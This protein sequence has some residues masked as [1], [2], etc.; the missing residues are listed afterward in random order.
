MS[1]LATLRAG[2][3]PPKVALLPDGLFFTRAL[4]VA[5]GATP[6]EAATQIELGLEAVSPFPIA[7]LFYGYFWTPGAETAFVF[8]AY[9]RRFTAEQMEA[10]VGAELVLP[11]FA[12]L[13][14]A[15]VRPATTVILSSP[16][17]LTAVHWNNGRVPSAV[18]FRPLPPVV[19]GTPEAEPARIEETRDRLREELIHEV[20]GS[21]S[22]IDLAVPPVADPARSDREVTFRSGEL[23]SKLDASVIA[24]LDV[25]DKGELAALR[26]ARRRDV[27]LWR[28]AMGCV[29]ALVLL[30]VGE[31]GLI[32]GRAWQRVRDKKFQAQKPTVDKIVKT[33]ELARR[34]EDLATKR[35][36]PWEMMM[37]VIGEKKERLPGE[38]YFGRV[39]TTTEG[40]IYSISIEAQTTNVGSISIY[41][42]AL[43]AMPGVQNVETRNLQAKSDN[44]TFTFFITFQPD[45]IKPGALL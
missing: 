9:R 30:G 33:D 45:A 20:G 13:L 6:A 18:I 14:G 10:W 40:G 26:G 2:P 19:E 7:Q 44:A 28:V 31:F 1:F 12:A 17:G 5:A 11:A 25:R 8:A 34:I 4:P 21:R 24:A 16:E 23:V 3:P 22:V 37:A 38:I 39:Y 15:E 35:L 29:A 42:S 36:L 41:S 43:K 32:G 27:I